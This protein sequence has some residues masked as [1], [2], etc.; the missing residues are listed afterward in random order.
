MAVSTKLPFITVILQ[1]QHHLQ[2]M[3]VIFLNRIM[4]N[5]QEMLLK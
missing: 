5:H 3:R 4:P 2:N 1:K